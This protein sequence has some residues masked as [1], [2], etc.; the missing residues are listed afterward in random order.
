MIL[1]TGAI[2]NVGRNVVSL[3]L[4]AGEQ[5]ARDEVTHLIFRTLERPGR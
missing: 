3:L 5:A 1:V 2:G 4:E